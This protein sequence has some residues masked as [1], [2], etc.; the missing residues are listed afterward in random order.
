MVGKFEEL[1]NP[2]N[3]VYEFPE[4]FKPELDTEEESE[5]LKKYNEIAKYDV[6]ISDLINS[7]FLISGESLVM[8]YKPR[9]GK[10]RKYHATVL[11]DGSLELLGQ[12]FSSPSYAALSGIQDAG[13]ERKT[14]NGWVAWKNH[15]NLTLADL[16]DQ[17]LYKLS[18]DGE[19]EN[20]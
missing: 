15:Q 8:I 2:S 1:N 7:G 12:Q 3:I 13:S 18:K 11:E 4:E 20:D 5:P 14:V 9:N 10:Q 6:Q 16:R 19:S 17:Y